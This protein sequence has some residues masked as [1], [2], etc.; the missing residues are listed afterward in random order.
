[1]AASHFGCTHCGNDGRLTLHSITAASP[2]SYA[3][4]EVGY[5]C[6]S[7][8]VHYVGRADAA[9]VAAVLSRL[10]SPPGVMVFGGHYVHCGQPMQRLGSEV[11]QLSAP[12]FSAGPPEEAFG[13]HVTARVLRCSCGFQM[14]VLDQE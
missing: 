12:G 6:D 1:M 2:P 3:L 5:S 8:N 7:C 4:V 9:A 11:R 10:H 14:D 13:V